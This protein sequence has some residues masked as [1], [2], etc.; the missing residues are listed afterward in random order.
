M[1]ELHCYRSSASEDITEERAVEEF[2]GFI[3]AQSNSRVLLSMLWV[4]A[5]D[6]TRRWMRENG[7]DLKRCQIVRVAQQ[8]RILNTKSID[9]YIE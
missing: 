9:T 4:A 8:A 6:D 3:Q 7:I 2:V 1:S 5:G